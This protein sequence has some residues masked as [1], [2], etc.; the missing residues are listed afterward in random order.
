MA[1]IN[2]EPTTGPQDIVEL[3]LQG[4]RTIPDL[5]EVVEEPH[6]PDIEIWGEEAVWAVILDVWG[7]HQA[8]SSVVID[9]DPP[10]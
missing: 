10:P 3:Q 9:H 2:L 7:L 5:I 8:D 4:V 1:R 6:V